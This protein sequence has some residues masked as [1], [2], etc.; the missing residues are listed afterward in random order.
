MQIDWF[1][2][3]LNHFETRLLKIVLD[4]QKDTS[5][6]EENKFKTHNTNQD[7]KRLFKKIQ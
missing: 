5:P 3:D 4:E 2:Y 1:Q 6:V 7:D